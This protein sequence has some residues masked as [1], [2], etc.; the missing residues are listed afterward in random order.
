MNEEVIGWLLRGDPSIRF[1]TM[2]DLMDVHGV[3]L[4]KEQK[5]IEK[6]G[7]GKDRKSVV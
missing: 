7:W 6:R 2:R 4:Q 5:E 3:Q 1:Q